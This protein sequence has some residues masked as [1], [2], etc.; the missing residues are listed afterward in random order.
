MNGAN[1]MMPPSNYGAYSD[2]HGGYAL[3][4]S[5]HHGTP[6]PQ[7]DFFPGSVKPQIYT[8]RLDSSAADKR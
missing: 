4:Q 1:G 5:Q 7:P 2:H 3:A 6:Q 8:V